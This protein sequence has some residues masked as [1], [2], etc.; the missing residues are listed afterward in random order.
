MNLITWSKGK[1]RNRLNKLIRAETRRSMEDMIPIIS[2]VIDCQNS[3]EDDRPT[4]DRFFKDPFGNKDLYFRLKDRLLELGVLVDEVEINRSEF[5]HWLNDFPELEKFYQNSGDTQIEKC[6]EHYLAFKHLRLS[7]KDIYVDIGAEDSPWATVLNKRN[8]KS[9]S[10][11]LSHPKGIRGF[12][13]GADA[14]ETTLPD[15]FATALSAQCA[16]EHFMGDADINFI[17]EAGR[18]LNKEGRFG[19]LP[20]YLND[21][22]I[23]S[24]SPYCNQKDISIDSEAKRIWRTDGKKVPFAR[25]YSPEYFLKRI[26]SNI[27]GKMLGKL[28]FFKNLPDIMKHYQGQRIYCFFMLFCEVQKNA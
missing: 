4:C 20:I 9:F 21:E 15:G 18:I 24:T 1:V 13:I 5:E 22:Y 28:F 14:S 7:K 12:N 3:S 6:L 19:I 26:Y 2:Q 23:V 8:I 16:F 17:A 25:L 11:D 10:L 27:P